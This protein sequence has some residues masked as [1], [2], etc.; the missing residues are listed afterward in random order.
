MRRTSSWL[1][2]ITAL[3]LSLGLSSAA[4]TTGAAQSLSP[5]G[6]GAV[7]HAQAATT[8]AAVNSAAIR[9]GLELRH[10]VTKP[11]PP[12]TASAFV[13]AAII[14]IGLVAVTV[15][16]RRADPDVR[17]VAFAHGARAPPVVTGN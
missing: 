1:R 16:R 15:R 14:L 9:S 11:R 4:A 7:T 13:V 8:V 3:V 17:H 6:V 5:T 2:L 12:A 10:A